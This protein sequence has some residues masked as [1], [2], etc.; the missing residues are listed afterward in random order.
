LKCGE[1]TALSLGKPWGLSNIEAKW[2]LPRSPWRCIDDVE[3]EN[4]QEEEVYGITGEGSHQG[5]AK[6]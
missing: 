1:K 5:R 2:L 3:V 4:E 6:Q